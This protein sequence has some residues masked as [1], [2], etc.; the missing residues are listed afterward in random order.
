[1]IRAA[2]VG[3]G[4]WGGIL[5]N[6]VQGKSDKISFTSIVSR[7]PENHQKFAQN[8]GMAVYDNLDAVLAD[9]DIDAVT[10]VTPTQMHADQV[11]Q[12]AAAGKHLFVEKPF[13][14]ELSDAKRAVDAVEKAGVQLAVGF[15]RRFLPAIEEIRQRASQ[16][17]LGTIIHMEGQFSGPTAF[18][19]P[20]DNWRA[21]REANP[22]G[23]MVPR[24]IHS[25]DLM[26]SFLGNVTSVFA[27]S[28]CRA[29]PTGAD[30]VTSVLLTFE[31]GATAY[32]SSI[33]ITGNYFR[34]QFLGTEGWIEVMGEEEMIVSDLDEIKERKTF[35]SFDKE[36]AELEAFA[37]AING[38]KPFQVKPSEV[39]HGVAVHQAI[40]HSA[41]T[42][43]PVTIPE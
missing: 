28:D 4:R 18:R 37:D 24:G 8:H 5:V 34:T 32:L 42:G 11:E 35:E 14:F 41:E 16:G 43:Q 38:I 27:L 2:I 17:E 21:T 20:V 23:G 9:P 31:S 39:I 12:V 36:R 1:M 19:T 26:I 6:S 29:S 22:A 25:L 40:V 13:A 3:L 7:T 33:M 10:L 15:N 30:D